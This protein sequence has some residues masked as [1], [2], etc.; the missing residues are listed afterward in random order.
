MT[1]STSRLTA[2]GMPAALALAMG[3]QNASGLTTTGSTKATALVL[4]PGANLISTCASAGVA[5]CLLPFAEAIGDVVVMNGGASSAL[6][7]A[8]AG[9]TINALS[10]G[11]SFSVTNGKQAIFISAKKANSTPPTG[12]WVAILSA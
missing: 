8:Q 12:A 7:F 11:A 10:T 9:E 6:V 3:Q 1:V 5:A 2:L 4:I